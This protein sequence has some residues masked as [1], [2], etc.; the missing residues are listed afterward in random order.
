MSMH[1]HQT[2]PPQAA[3]DLI[4]RLEPTPTLCTEL[5]DLPNKEMMRSRMRLVSSLS[6]LSDDVP[7]DCLDLLSSALEVYHH[8][9][10]IHRIT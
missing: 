9:N 1:L 4:D 6:G 2:R 5:K 7:T 3:I 10:L 8:V